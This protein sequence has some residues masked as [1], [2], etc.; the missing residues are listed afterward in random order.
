MAE[1]GL[2]VPSRQLPG[3]SNCAVMKG[4]FQSV[5]VAK[6]PPYAFSGGLLSTGKNQR[7]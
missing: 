3:L 6:S 2:S 4:S 1:C 7:P 5:D